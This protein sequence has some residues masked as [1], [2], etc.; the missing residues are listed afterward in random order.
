MFLASQV[1]FSFVN[2]RTGARTRKSVIVFFTG[3]TYIMYIRETN[4]RAVIELMYILEKYYHESQRIP[5]EHTVNYLDAITDR[6]N[7]TVNWK[8]MSIEY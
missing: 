7:M 3:I 1:Q 8:R 6:I 4:C 5:R 2:A